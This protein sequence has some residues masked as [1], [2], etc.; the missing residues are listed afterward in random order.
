MSALPAKADIRIIGLA[1]MEGLNGGNSRPTSRP[2]LSIKELIAK[3]LAD[4]DDLA[5][6]SPI[7][8][9][10]V[11]VYLFAMSALP[12]KQTSFSTAAMAALCQ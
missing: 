10:G 5:H 2:R 9:S 1:T 11:G 6:L 12:L 4:P 7:K 3:A 8:A